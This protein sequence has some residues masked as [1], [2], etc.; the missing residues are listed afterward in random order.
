MRNRENPPVAPSPQQNQ[1]I[2]PNTYFDDEEYR[3]NIEDIDMEIR[4]WGQLI[5]SIVN[6]LKTTLLNENIFQIVKTNSKK[7]NEKSPILEQ[8]SNIIFTLFNLV[9]RVDRTVRATAYHA[10][11]ELLSREE[12]PKELL[13]NDDKLKNILRPILI[14][15]QHDFKKFMPSFL[16]VFRKILKLLTQCFNNA[17][18][19]KL[20][21]HLSEIEKAKEAE[22]TT[23]ATRTMNYAELTHEAK[24]ISS[25]LGLFQYL[26][27]AYQSTSPKHTINSIE[28]IMQHTTVISRYFAPKLGRQTIKILFKENLA[29]LVNTMSPWFSVENLFGDAK[30]GFLQMIAEIIR[31][32]QSYAIREK[33]TRD[34]N[35]A[36]R[37]LD[38]KHQ[39]EDYIT[40]L[41]ILKTLSKHNTHWLRKN[42][43]FMRKLQVRFDRAVTE[44]IKGEERP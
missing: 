29:K 15:L 7:K 37:I 34:I 6:F 43:G 17:L 23:G 22:L 10:L 20:L 44:R 16:Y 41:E 25:L 31:M 8:R 42:T 39:Y 36:D 14:C 13:S 30:K 40:I 1:S 26:S 2:N 11:K 28:K 32:P 3:L 9:A 24:C 5:A 27:F 4:I 33:I 19:I 12:H 18:I 21:N 38:E 35:F